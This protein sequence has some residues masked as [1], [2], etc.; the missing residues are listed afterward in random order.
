MPAPIGTTRSGPAT[1]STPPRS[2]RSMPTPAR[3]R[4]HYQ[5]TPNDVYDY[6]AVQIP[7]LV[8]NWAG[9]ASTSWRGPTA[10]AISTCS[11]ARRAASCSGKPFVKVNWM[12]KFDEQRP[13]ESDSAAGG[14]ADLPGQPGRN[15]LV[16]AVVQSAHG[17]LLCVRVGRLREHL[18]A[19]A[20]GVQGRHEF[21]RRRPEELSAGARR[22]RSRARSRS[23]RGPRRP[24][25]AR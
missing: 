5:F 2:S 10:T 17:A 13:A 25:T 6:D 19:G 4:W 21:R 24:V 23:T 11:I 15:Q 9:A 12:S 20:A 3:L 18:R 7:V 14:A 16:L 8:D 1:I 22:A